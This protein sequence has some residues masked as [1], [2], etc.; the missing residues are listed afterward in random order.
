MSSLLNLKNG[1][2][3]N[4]DFKQVFDVASGDGAITIPTRGRKH[5]FVTKASAAALTL[6]APTATAHDGVEIVIL[7]DFRGKLTKEIF[8]V[9]GTVAEFDAATAQALLDEQRAEPAEVEEETAN[10]R[11]KRSTKKAK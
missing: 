11:Q 4:S 6:A 8:Y 3:D 5:V 9:A 10:D 1:T 2:A 7:Q